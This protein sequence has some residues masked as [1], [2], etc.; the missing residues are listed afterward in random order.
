MWIRPSAR[1][2]GSGKALPGPSQQPNQAS[3]AED[4]LP[5]SVLA[6]AIAGP[7]VERDEATRISMR[8]FKA[9]GTK[10]VFEKGARRHSDRS[11]AI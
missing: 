2:H 1:I 3:R 8:D 7:A 5:A 4:L 6:V 9:I 10:S 11:H